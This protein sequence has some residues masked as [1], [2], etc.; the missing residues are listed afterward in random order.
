VLLEDKNAVIYGGGGSV[1]GAVARAFAREGARVFL[2]GRTLA[3]VEPVAQEIRAVG[4]VAEA[5]RVD[6]LDETAVD[7]HADAVAAKAGGIDVS[8]NAI[9]N[10][11]VQ[12]TPLAEMPFDDFARPIT[13]AMRSEFL[14]ARAV[15]RHMVERG[16][17]VILTITG[18]YREAFPTIGGT[19]VAWAAIEAQCRQ[20][21]C[22][23]GP[24][25]VRVVWLRTTG[26]P[27]TIPDTG[28]AA[29]DLGT[30]YGE[31]MTREE[32]ITG[33]R[34]QTILKR[35]ASLDEL[36]NVAAFMASDGAGPMTA[37]FANITCGAILD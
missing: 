26:L 4:G 32:I 10:D 31:G 24:Q 29:A 28:D 2:A 22:E 12:G 33:M 11:D 3:R 17:G 36:G 21:A 27:E 5:A 23:L 9:F 1:G 16:S 19:V 13:K 6:V 8:F 15:A 25:G 30:G 18:G 20:W 37:T 7:E 14:T 35:L 34:E